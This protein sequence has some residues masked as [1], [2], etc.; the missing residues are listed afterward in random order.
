MFSAKAG[1]L[2]LLGNCTV[3]RIPRMVAFTASRSVGL[4]CSA[5]LCA[6]LT[7]EHRRLIVAGMS[8]ASAKLAR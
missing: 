3:R 6:Y 8:P 5:S 7:A 1:A 2:R 4:S